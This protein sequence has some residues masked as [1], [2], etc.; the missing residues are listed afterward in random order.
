[1]RGNLILTHNETLVKTRTKSA[2]PFKINNAEYACVKNGGFF[3]RIYLTFKVIGFVWGKS[4]ALIPEHTNLNEPHV[5]EQPKDYADT[6][7]EGREDCP[8]KKSHCDYYSYQC[9]NNGE[10]AIDHCGHPDN[11][12]G[13]VEGNA[14]AYAC[15]LHPFKSE[16]NN[17]TTV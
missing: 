13:D 5:K 7:T 3:G 14:V 4:E 17:D 15:P 6:E 2:A 11:T 12:E 8:V 16:F 10:V 9:D 1:M